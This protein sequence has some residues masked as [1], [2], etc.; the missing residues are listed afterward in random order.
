MWGESSPFV[1]KLRQGRTPLPGRLKGRRTGKS[2]QPFLDQSQLYLAMPQSRCLSVDRSGTVH[3]PGCS[4]LTAFLKTCR[5]LCHQPR[6]C[7]TRCH[8]RGA[9][10]RPPCGPRG[11]LQPAGPHPL[12]LL[13]ADFTAKP[14]L[15]LKVYRLLLLFKF[16][17]REQAL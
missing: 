6:P 13:A 7:D 17:F 16:L 1:S 12:Q 14:P 2:T 8:S 9:T 3:S 4:S 11:L 15:W 5:P 10:H